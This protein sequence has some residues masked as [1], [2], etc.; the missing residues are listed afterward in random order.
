MGPQPKNNNLLVGF[1]VAHFGNLTRY[2]HRFDHRSFLHVH[3]VR[4]WIA[5]VRLSDI[6]FGQCAIVGRRRCEAII[7]TEII[8]ATMAVFVTILNFISTNIFP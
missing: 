8:R 6:E 5:E 4:D 2:S 1:H 7:G 3:V